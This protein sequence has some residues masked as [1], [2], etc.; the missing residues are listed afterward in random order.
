MDLKKYNYYLAIDISGWIDLEYS[1]QNWLMGKNFVD[2]DQLIQYRYTIDKVDDKGQ[3]LSNVVKSEI[4]NTS[5]ICKGS[6][7]QAN[8]PE[9]AVTEFTNKLFCRMNSMINYPN[10]ENV[11]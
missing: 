7:K 3:F 4:E 1:R 8:D 2:H 9:K 6:F 11:N 10:Y 5:I